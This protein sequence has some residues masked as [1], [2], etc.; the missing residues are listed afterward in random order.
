M[1]LEDMLTFRVLL[2]KDIM[3][4]S[5]STIRY[6]P[7]ISDVPYSEISYGATNESFDGSTSSTAISEAIVTSPSVSFSSFGTKVS[8]G[9]NCVSAVPPMLI[10]V[11]APNHEPASPLSEHD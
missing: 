1:S 9:V 2:S 4:S 5:S 6:V 10:R 7:L 11:G 3:I 8:F